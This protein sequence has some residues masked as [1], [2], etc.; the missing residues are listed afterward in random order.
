MLGF[1]NIHDYSK[2]IFIY[3]KYLQLSHLDG[4]HYEVLRYATVRSLN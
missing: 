2:W 1:V 4:L 3:N